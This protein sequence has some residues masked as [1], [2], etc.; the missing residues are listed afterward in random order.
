MASRSGKFKSIELQVLYKSIRRSQSCDYFSLAKR[1][2]A[3]RSNVTRLQDGKSLIFRG[4]PT[5]N[6]RSRYSFIVEV[7]TAVE[8][9]VGVSLARNKIPYRYLFTD[10]GFLERQLLTPAL[11][12]SPWHIEVGTRIRMHASSNREALFER[13]ISPRLPRQK[14]FFLRLIFP[15]DLL[16]IEIFARTCQWTY[17]N[18]FM[19][20]TNK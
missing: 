16:F 7:I 20:L 15:L 5:K 6:R 12:V 11:I 19:S 3:W 14:R 18:V 9:P 8:K 13:P 10:S 1:S 2:L 4:R 17:K